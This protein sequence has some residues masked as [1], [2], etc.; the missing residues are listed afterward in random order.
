MHAVDGPAADVDREAADGTE[1][2]L[3]IF[4]REKIVKSRAA[5]DDVCDRIILP[6]FMKMEMINV[7][8]MDFRFRPGDDPE[9]FRG[10]IFDLSR[11]SGRSDSRDD[12]IQMSFIVPGAF[13]KTDV[14]CGNTGSFD[15]AHTEFHIRAALGVSADQV[16]ICAEID[17]RADD[18]VT[19]SA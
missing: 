14:R 16:G 1:M 12:L 17:E 11:Q 18:H 4:V 3:R 10:I 15:T 6:G 2:Q 8:V 5:A 19:G 13:F 9:N 7:C